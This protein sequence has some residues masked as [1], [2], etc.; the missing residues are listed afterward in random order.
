MGNVIPY[1]ILQEME[2]LLNGIRDRI[3]FQST[4]NFPQFWA[5]I[6][7]DPVSPRPV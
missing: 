4:E 6:Y 2:T 1:T 5:K 7:S 3:L